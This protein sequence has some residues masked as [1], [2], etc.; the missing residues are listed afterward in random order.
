MDDSKGGDRRP[1]EEDGPN[2]PGPMM[3]PDEIVGEDKH[4]GKITP[5]IH[6]A[7]GETAPSAESTRLPTLGSPSRF[8][9]R[10]SI[11]QHESD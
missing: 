8:H 9:A 1:E 5:A 11:F 4:V 6:E 10:V 2:Q 7:E 3:A